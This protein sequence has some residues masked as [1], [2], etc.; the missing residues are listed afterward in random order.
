MAFFWTMV[1]F[2]IIVGFVAAIL[3]RQAQSAFISNPGLNGLI[4]GVLVSI[5][6]VGAG[7]LPGPRTER[8]RASRIGG[9]LGGH[10]L[11][12]SRSRR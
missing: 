11:R 1:I 4:L 5:S 12:R 7:A 3:F 2:L 8:T 9:G 6:S 10:P